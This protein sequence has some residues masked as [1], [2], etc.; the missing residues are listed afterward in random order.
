MKSEKWITPRNLAIFLTVIYVIS[1]I[2]LLWIARY[3]FPSADDYTNGSVCFHVW[4]KEHSVSGVIAEAFL[5]TVDEWFHWRGCFTSSFLSALTPNIW[6]ENVY[7]ITT[8]LVLGMLSV[9]T[10]Y[11]LH[12]IFTKVFK[13][14]NYTGH[15]IAMLVLLV[16]VH[17][18]HASGRVEA[19]YW[20]SGA[21]NYVFVH[22]VSLLFYGL[23][24]SAIYDKGKK[25]TWDVIGASVLGFL[26]SGGNQMTMLNAAIVLFLGVV[27]ITL[28]KKWKEYKMLAFPV[29]IFYIGFVMAVT[30]PGNFVRAGSADGMNPVKAILVS[31]YYCLELALGEW[32]TWPVLIAGVMM[33]PLFWH[34]TKKTDFRFP[35]PAVVA[36]FGYCLVSAMITPPLF[37]IGNFEA[38]RL[39]ALTYI[40]YI[41]IVTLCLGYVTGWARKKYDSKGRKALTENADSGYGKDERLCLLGCLIFLGF[42]SMLMIIPEPHFYTFSSAVTEL[43]SGDA[44]V[45]GEALEERIQLYR[46]NAAG[47][48]EVKALKVQPALLFFSDISEDEED[49]KNQGLSR[50]YDLEAVS[51]RESG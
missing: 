6:G 21:I 40:M 51:V 17:C 38:G 10:I 23:L 15:C 19:F 50:Y 26:T 45:Y 13:A 29:G 4:E 49:W 8:W 14:D 34:M 42:G 7:F 18:M 35:Y 31:F 12:T 47:K 33:V 46:E 30:A 9:S 27:F 28:K 20:Y 37:A 1:I 3:N 39:Q 5:R 43:K 44:K 41:L 24:I 48:V 22:G 32:T 11:L 16:T 2:P 36:V 25:R